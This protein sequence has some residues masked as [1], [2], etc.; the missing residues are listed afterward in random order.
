MPGVSWS[1][2]KP[3]DWLASNGRWYEASTRPRGWSTSALPPAPGHGG[4]G[5]ILRRIAETGSTAAGL[6]SSDDAPKTVPREPKARRAS[7][8]TQESSAPPRPSA[9]PSAH[10]APT[11]RRVAQATITEA[12]ERDNPEIPPPPGRIRPELPEPAM[13]APPAPR[14]STI[15]A[16]IP[17][18]PAGSFEVVAGDLGKVLG[19]AKKRIEKAINEAAES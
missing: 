3:T 16:P 14:V 7:S 1:Q 12:Y 11:G 10:P 15:P 5:S 8:V 13:P 6:G 19:T 17:P 2:R 18:E 9:G 4:V